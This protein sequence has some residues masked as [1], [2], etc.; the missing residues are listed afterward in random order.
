MTHKREISVLGNEASFTLTANTHRDKAGVD[1]VGAGATRF[2]QQF[3]PV[4]IV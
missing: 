4:V 2:G 3:H 1:V